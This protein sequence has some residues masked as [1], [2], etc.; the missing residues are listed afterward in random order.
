MITIDVVVPSYR[1]DE[2]CLMAI[3][4]LHIPAACRVNF[5]IIVDNPSSAIPGTILEASKIRHDFTLLINE[6]NLG[7][8]ATRNKGMRAGNGEY[9]LLLDDDIIPEP[10]LLHNYFYAIRSHPSAIGFAGPVMFPESFNAVTHSLRI[11]GL[12]TH[13]EKPAYADNV[14]WTPTA[15]VLMKR[16]LLPP[17][18]FDERMIYGGEDI[19]LLSA[20]SLQQELKWI[21]VPEA[22]VY[23]PWW[24]GGSPQLKKMFSY[25]RGSVDAIG[26]QHIRPYSFIDF[27]NVCEWSL[28]LLLLSPLFFMKSMMAIWLW[29]WVIF[30]TA[31]YIIAGMQCIV[32][33]QNST[34]VAPQFFLHKTSREAGASW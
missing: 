5:F 4:A 24:G 29:L 21:C 16:V 28:I 18:L 26:K 15:N 14:V 9:V 30:W 23:H 31:E 17:Q 19:D 2:Q 32:A 6:V 10:N 27:P 13:F 25:G 3:L 20:I 34:T 33:K 7:F 22:K 1:V 11:L 12:P 8:S